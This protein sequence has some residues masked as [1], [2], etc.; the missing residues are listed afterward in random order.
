MRDPEPKSI[1]R[2][3][4]RILSAAKSFRR[5]ADASTGM[6][7]TDN[8]YD[9]HPRLLIFD[10]VLNP[11]D[12]LVWL[13]IRSRCTPDM[14]LAAFPSYDE[15]Q[16]MLHISRGTVSSSIAKLRLTRWIT[17]LC[18]DQERNAS[19]QFTRDG[20]IYMVHGEPLDVSDTFDLDANYMGYVTNCRKHR[21]NDV[22]KIAEL[23]LSSLRHDLSLGHNVTAYEHPFERRADAWMALEGDI[24]ASFFGTYPDLANNNNLIAKEN[25]FDQPWIEKITEVHEMNYGDINNL[26]IDEDKE[27]VQSDSVVPTSSNRV[28]KNNNYNYQNMEE[29]TELASDLIFPEQVTENQKHLIALTLKRLPAGLPEP[30]KPWDSWHQLLLDELDGRIKAGLSNRCS[31]V[32]NPVSLMTTY[33][34]RLS[35]NGIGLREDGQFQIENAEG[36]HQQRIDLA[37]QQALFERTKERYRQ[38][39]LEQAKAVHTKLET[40]SQAPAK[41]PN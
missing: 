12:K 10:P 24:D 39:V 41:D 23:I 35:Q 1:K 17:H 28:V 33:C 29:H 34:K 13:A 37:K 9:S 7:F 27:P 31:P 38:R 3:L 21:N 5:L 6:V 16:S 19:G 20:N 8:W 2:N 32:W 15:I 30:P 26:D 14:S 40:P 36:I 4:S 22:R 11:Y 25:Q 18:R